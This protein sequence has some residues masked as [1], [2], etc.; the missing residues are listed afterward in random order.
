M[1][2]TDCAIVISKHSLQDA[3]PEWNALLRDDADSSLF[4]R[5][6]W[7]ETWWE[8]FDGAQEL[9]LYVVREESRTLGLAPFVQSGETISFLGGPDLFDYHD[10]LVAP[11]ATERFVELLFRELDRSDT[12]AKL[13]LKS[14]PEWSPSLRA[15]ERV[16]ESRGWRVEV[17]LEDVAP[18][19]A[20]PGSWEDYLGQLSKKNRH[21]LRRKL[22][23]LE[24]AGEVE[25]VF[26]QTVDEIDAHFAEFAHLHRIGSPEKREFLTPKREAFFR[27]LA[28]RLAANGRTRLHFLKIGGRPVASSFCFRSGSR[29]FVYNSGLDPEYREWSVGLM[30]HALALQTAI[31]EGMTECHFLRGNERY[32]YNL[33]AQDTHLFTVTVHRSQD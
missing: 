33:G 32:K 12:W 24:S 20:L 6:E 9:A 17:A 29:L 2:T 21:E 18:V 27:D 23:R 5:P 28:L 31:R 30:N 3:L 11:G 22:R 26:Y 15:I 4:L 1:C 7:Y 10:F 8:H 14:V 16:A 25:H 13:D 19:I